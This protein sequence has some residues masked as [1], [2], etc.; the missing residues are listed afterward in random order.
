MSI[1]NLTHSTPGL[2]QTLWVFPTSQ[3]ELNVRMGCYDNAEARMI[4][5]NVNSRL[6]L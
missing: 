4:L 5:P 2:E 6:N 3:S 1:P